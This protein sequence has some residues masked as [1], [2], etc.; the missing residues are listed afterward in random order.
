MRAHVGQA[1]V[2]IGEGAFDTAADEPVHRVL[3]PVGSERRK[4]RTERNRRAGFAL[5]ELAETILWS[6]RLVGE[7]V[8]E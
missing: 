1:G 2:T 8:R 6:P 4:D 3:H 5:P 7:S